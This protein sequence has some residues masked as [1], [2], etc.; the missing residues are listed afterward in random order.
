VAHAGLRL[1]EAAKLGFERAWVPQGTAA[2]D[3][4]ALAAFD[5]L[6]ALV[7]QILGR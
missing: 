4:I 6:R 3:G 2:A 7:D 5:S 1:K